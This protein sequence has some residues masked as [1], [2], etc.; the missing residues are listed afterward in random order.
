MGDDL[1][2]KNAQS[3]RQFNVTNADLRPYVDRFAEK[4]LTYGGHLEVKISEIPVN[5]GDTGD[6]VGV[7]LIYTNNEREV[8]VDLEWWNKQGNRRKELLIFHELGHCA[9]GRHHDDSKVEGTN[10]ATTIMN[11][12]LISSKDYINFLDPYHFELF[13]GSSDALTSA[14]KQ[15]LA[16]RSG[17]AFTD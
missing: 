15:L 3:I 10:Y 5:F 4:Y 12:T 9:L 16:E 14:V 1:I 13:T 11:P 17:V 2:Y 6:K 7:C 8:L